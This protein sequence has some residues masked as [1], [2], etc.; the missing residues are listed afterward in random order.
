ML[1]T[2]SWWQPEL[3]VYLQAVEGKSFIFSSLESWMKW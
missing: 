1:S 2:S 3:V